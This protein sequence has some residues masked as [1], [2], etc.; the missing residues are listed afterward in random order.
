MRDIRLRIRLYTVGHA[1]VAM[2]S[3]QKTFV[4]EALLSL[5]KIF[6]KEV[7][8]LSQRCTYC[9]HTVDWHKSAFLNN[10]GSKER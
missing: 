5:Q 8:L 3:V 6:A 7:K 1:S 2:L 4:A 10:E 9:L